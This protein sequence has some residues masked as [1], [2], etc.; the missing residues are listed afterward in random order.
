MTQHCFN[1]RTSS[2][3]FILTSLILFSCTRAKEQDPNAS[4]LQI[5]APRT[6][7]S[8][9]I[10][11][12]SA[13]TDVLTHLV[14]NITASDI[15]PIVVVQD[16]HDA[17]TISNMI[18][19]VTTK[20]ADRLVQV[21][22]VYESGTTGDG[23]M[24][25]YYGSTTKTFAADTESVAI[26]INPIG[27]GADVISGRVSGRYITSV[28]STIPHGPT[29]Q[30]SMKYYP[31][32]STNGLII[33][34]S[35]MYDGWFN[36]MMLDSTDSSI[37][38]TYE[39][40]DGTKLWGGPV[41][42]SSTAFTPSNQ[43]LKVGIPVN[44]RMNTSSGGSF[45]WESNQPQE[46]IYGFFGDSSLISTR[47]VC[48]P[49]T[50]GFT[51][52][53]ALTKVTAWNATAPAANSSQT[54]LTG[55]FVTGTFPTPTALASTSSPS[56]AYSLKGGPS[57]TT[58]CSS[59]TDYV[60][61]ISLPNLYSMIDGNGS[62]GALYHYLPLRAQVVNNGTTT[63]QAP[64]SF[65]PDTP[66]AG[67]YR[68]VGQLL[69]G[70][71]TSVAKI[72]AYKRVVSDSWQWTSDTV[73]CADISMAVPYGGVPFASAANALAL[74]TTAFNYDVPVS[75]A[76]VNT[77]TTLAFC[78]EDAN[79]LTLPNLGVFIRKDNLSGYPSS[80]AGAASK[81]AISAPSAVNSNGCVDMTVT[82]LDVNNLVAVA[83]GTKSVSLSSL[84]SGTSTGAFYSAGSSCTGTPITSVSFSST[85]STKT[86]QFKTSISTT[87]TSMLGVSAT[88][89]TS[90][91]Q[92]LPVVSSSSATYL[93]FS[94][95]GRL[96]IPGTCTEVVLSAKN[97]AGSSVSGSSGSITLTSTNANF[98]FYSDSGCATPITA[99]VSMTGGSV[100]VY[101]NPT[102]A[103][104]TT[105]TA[106]MP[107]TV[108]L[109]GTKI[110]SILAAG[111][112]TKLTVTHGSGFD[113]TNSLYSNQCIPYKVQA[114]DDSAT[115]SSLT[116]SLVVGTS[117]GV[118]YSDA[119]CSTALGTTA[120]TVT[121]IN[122]YNFYLKVPVSGTQVIDTLSASFVSTA[123]STVT[124]AGTMA[125]TVKA[126][127]LRVD[128]V[129]SGKNSFHA[130]TEIGITLVDAPSGGNPIVNKSGAS[131][132]TAFNM[133]K[134]SSPGTETTTEG[135]FCQDDQCVTPISIFT[136]VGAGTV[137]IA[138]GASA[139]TS[140]QMYIWSNN[141]TGATVNYS[142]SP[143]LPTTGY[144][145]ATDSTA[146]IFCDTADSTTCAP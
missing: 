45:T 59:A 79:G 81:L 64:L 18:D 39:L 125:D 58:A 32:G 111:V 36:F 56:T 24:S 86:V 5:V 120:F 113:S 138:N 136:N 117:G 8:Q 126:L 40:A 124:L 115:S 16:G 60:S 46:Y 52:P 26:S 34:T 66:V 98:I 108:T 131:I 89:L 3:L 90:A 71:E 137:S 85:D 4:R 109:S 95:A 15:T 146:L 44:Y 10:G 21:L 27:T 107:G 23:K 77:G 53:S 78:F 61:K 82:L 47:Y 38:F 17:G 97:T 110:V 130:P 119:N 122:Y 144:Q 69:P 55:T 100:S 7:M 48:R 75:V 54:G 128:E 140:T 13:S 83:G 68:F 11:S 105:I 143:T 1:K 70:L 127:Y 65:T 62:D 73:P 118:L 22:A 88:G 76:E 43:V 141:A 104:S 92:S 99:P 96:N 49:S 20:G 93:D 139:T 41:N 33:E 37:V 12:L 123:L 106:S 63:Y 50:S 67:S 29:G 14:I 28:A 132:L 121:G 94:L 51:T 84:N 116:G 101:I 114:V 112:A 31:P 19:V 9:K 72:H 42:M 25:F 57:S 145:A 134:D 103:L 133:T 80:V 142:S 74:T 2:L 129:D 135:Q 35:L 102:T 91:T 30:V 6:M 87:G